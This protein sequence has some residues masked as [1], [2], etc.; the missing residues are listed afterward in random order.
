[1]GSSS[2]G[3]QGIGFGL[4]LG[5]TWT[6]EDCV[7]RKDATF[8]YNIGLREG[9]L[10]L[11]CQKADVREA[12]AKTGNTR[13]IALCLDGNDTTTAATKRTARPA[14]NAQRA[15]VTRYNFNQ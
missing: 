12:I 11:M 10:A 7:R 4:S 6:D 14:T 13:L 5:T 1:M 2:A 3:G 9:A 15:G 8:L